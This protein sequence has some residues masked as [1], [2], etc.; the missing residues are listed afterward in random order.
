MFDHKSIIVTVNPGS[1]ATKVKAFSLDG[2]VLSEEKLPDIASFRSF[3]EK[4]QGTSEVVFGIRVVHGGEQDETTFVTDEVLSRI[5]EF[6]L[7]APIHNTLA[8]ER[9]ELIREIYPSSRVV[10][11]FDTH[12]HRTIPE[13][14]R[15]YLINREI[16]D[17]F[18]L[19]KYGFHGIALQSVVDT[20]EKQ[21]EGKGKKFPEK[22]VVAHL[23]GGCSITAIR[24]KKSFATT[25]ELTPVSGIPMIT[26]SGS[27]D[28][29][30]YPI[31]TAQGFS[32]EDVY[33]ILNN[34]SGFYGVLGSKDTKRI[35]EQAEHG[36]EG[37]LLAFRIFVSEIV[38]RISAY[39]GLMG[40]LDAIA[41]SGGIGYGNAFLRS[42][43]LEK[44]TS[45]FPLKEN[46]VHAIDVNEESV[47]YGE[48]IQLMV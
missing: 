4:L 48:I 12:F 23:G 7:F 8:V 38:Q 2:E 18:H 35:F 20:L 39:A 27:V 10:A 36:D 30:I 41:F 43:V 37:S 42:S 16:R 34:E 15:T 9:I 22:L 44:I 40:G 33:R 1:T 45:L 31:L 46:Q 13:E 28:L 3:L 32:V 19:R 47:M 6:T 17:R 29:G 11:I 26:R 5:R 21:Y 14:H 24:N 25:M